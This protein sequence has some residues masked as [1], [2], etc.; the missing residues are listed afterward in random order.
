[1]FFYINFF[2]I[3]LIHLTIKIFFNLKK[4]TFKKIFFIYL[5]FLSILIT[6]SIKKGILG[7]NINNQLNYLY[8]L[9]NLL[10]FLSY[11]LTIGLKTLD[12]PTFYILEYIKKNKK[13]KIELLEKYLQGKNLL[14]I[15]FQKLHEENLIKYKNNEIVLTLSG[16][17]FI[18]FMNIFS[19]SFNIIIEG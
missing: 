9:I 14:Q 6:I 4:L 19:K 5:F 3:L 8:I 10:I 15:R 13:V 12:S 7:L 2:F 18:R 1:M 17:F 16:K 11:I